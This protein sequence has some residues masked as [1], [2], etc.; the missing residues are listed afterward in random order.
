MP[1]LENNHGMAGGR[2][3]WRSNVPGVR[4]DICSTGYNCKQS[5]IR[6]GAFRLETGKR[7]A[8]PKLASRPFSRNHDCYLGKWS[9][10][11]RGF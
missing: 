3:V 5:D 10:A 2:R 8:R 1:F 4:V 6:R 11:V 9:D 7:H